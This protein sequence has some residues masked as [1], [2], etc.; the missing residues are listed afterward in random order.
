[1]LNYIATFE[2]LFFNN[3]NQSNFQNFHYVFAPL[4]NEGKDLTSELQITNEVFLIGWQLLTQLK[5]D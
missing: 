2:A 4:K 1:M 5:K 3:T